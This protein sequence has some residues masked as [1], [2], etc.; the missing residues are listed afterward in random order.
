MGTG[1]VLALGC[2]VGQ[3][4]TGLS[5]LAVGSVLAFAALV[6]GAVLGLKYLEHGSVVAA[7][8]AL[9]ART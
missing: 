6:A 7:L 5:T 3:G 8:K 4:I 2:T 1:G 9:T